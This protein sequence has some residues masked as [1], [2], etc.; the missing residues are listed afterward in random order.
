[1]LAGG[2]AILLASPPAGAHALLVSAEPSDG[3]SLKAPPDVV[4]LAF[5]E[6]PDPKL[7]FVRVLDASGRSYEQ[8]SLAAV[9]GQP[10]SI[11]A[12]VSG[13][14]KG[15]YTV[16]WR[17]VSRVDGHF[18]SGAYAFGVAVDPSEIEAV[19]VA[20]PRT[21]PLSP[22][23]SAG[24]LLL[25]VGLAGL[26]GMAWVGT[27][28]FRGV[29]RDARGMLLGAWVLCALGLILLSVAQ[30][31][32]AGAPWTAFIGSPIGRALVERGVLLLI[33]GAAI[34]AALAGR[35]PRGSLAV[36]L[37]AG[38]G[39][40]AVH[41]SA[42]HAGTGSYAW[43]KVATQLV[44]FSAIAVWIGGLA[45]VLVGIRGAPGEDKALAVRR[46]SMVAGATL[47]VVVG[48]GTARAVAEVGSWVGLFTTAYGRL[49]IVKVGLVAVIAAL[50]ARNRWWNVPRGAGGLPSLRRVS[51]FEL[52]AAGVVLV[53]TSVLASLVPAR[54]VGLAEPASIALEATDF[55]RSVRV[56]LTITP[57]FPGGNEFSADVETL[58]GSAPVDG[59]TL[60]L[61]S[62]EAGIQAATL[63]LRR[64]GDRWRARGAVVAVQGTWRVVVLVDRGAESVEVPLT[65]H[66]RCRAEAPTTEG[67]PRI[68]DIDLP[69]TGSVQAYVDPGAPGRNEVHFTF[70]DD[71]GKEL[72]MADDPRIDGFRERSKELDVRR[73]SSGHFV[74]GANLTDGRWIF[75]F[76]GATSDGDAVTVCFSDEI[77]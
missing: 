11:R 22:L 38:V 10:R 26:V 47:T 58:R 41:V 70:F 28:L 44:H 17:V 45:A 52:G 25:Y 12:R 6:E 18:T 77:R 15:V 32:A 29:S 50:A 14:G 21:M 55:A 16:S 56:G 30:K 1:M 33:A 46:F 43:V 61:S 40:I 34:A 8:G 19:D 72:P 42:G 59:V 36:A 75:S 51:R 13:L 68:Y 53:A 39:T 20:A 62:V 4:T 69:T 9:A 3:V 5:T 37:L 74:A 73:F 57:G 48:T 35:W 71:R 66:T 7:S 23:E 63:A 60:R 27:F 65:F 31:L 64:S 2:A 24:R 54:S 67:N 49:V 76:E